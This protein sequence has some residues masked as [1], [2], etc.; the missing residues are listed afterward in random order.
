MASQI[1]WPEAPRALKASQCSCDACSDTVAAQLES[2][3]L[4][5]DHFLS[6]SVQEIETRSTCLKVKPV[7]TAAAAGLRSFLADCVQ[8]AETL[9][10]A[11][12]LAAGPYRVRLHDIL[13]RSSHLNRSLRRSPRV[14]ASIPV[15]LRRE[16]QRH[17]WEEETWTSTASLHGAG[18]VCRHSVEVNGR[19][20][21]CRRDKG[22]RVEARVV[23][24]RFDSEGRRHIGVEILGR[25]D[26]WDTPELAPPSLA[27]R[28]E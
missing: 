11:E 2:R 21:L 12:D 18:F 1:A 6:I 10:G 28:A 23:Y 20:V 14:P 24:S 17:T 16:D 15:W 13:R 7:D 27:T 25:G 26:F 9:A 3:P 5:L 22:R 4:C 19:V 8:Q